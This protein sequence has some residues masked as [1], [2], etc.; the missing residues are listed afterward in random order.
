MNQRLNRGGAGRR[1]GAL[2]AVLW[3]SAALAAIAFSVATT[4]RG[5]I[6]RASTLADGVKTYYLATGALERA[7]LHLV[8]GPRN[9]SQNSTVYGRESSRMYFPFP[10]GEAVVEVIPET[11]RLSLNL[12]KREDFQGLLLSLGAEPER[13]SEIA[14]GILDWRGSG[15]GGAFDRFYSAQTPSF[16]ARHASF[17]E[18]E[19]VLF[20]KGMTPELFHG[21]YGRDRS[22]RLVRR[23]AFKD[24]VSVYGTAGRF[25]VNSVDPAMLRWLGIPPEAV[26]R[27]VQVRSRQ[28]IRNVSELAQLG[29]GGAG[30]GRLSVG[31]NTIF[32][33]RA[34]A[35]LRLPSGQFSDLRRGV[36]AQVKLVDNDSSAR[37][38][39]LR[40][41]DNA[42]AEV[43][44]WQ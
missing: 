2:L 7:L 31:G 19:E 28:R 9:A 20:V 22:G 30:M 32:T 44:Q 5:E 8:W 16:Q 6:E 12:G 13:A 41:N 24:C 1:G 26:D 29:V 10:T 35:R 4:V 43:P 38:Q 39:I 15:A 23:G 25:D 14:A 3:L 33:L 36:S 11:A 40:W 21:S 37:Y 34:A 18:V 27:I 42:Q 17:E